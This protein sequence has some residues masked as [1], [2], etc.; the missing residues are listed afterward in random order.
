MSTLRDLFT[1]ETLVQVAF[2]WLILYWVL[3][4]LETTVAGAF[5][6]G[7][8]FIA[9]LVVI[10]LMRVFAYFELGL[11]KCLRASF[12][13]RGSSFHTAYENPNLTPNDAAL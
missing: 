7:V 9:I 12:T 11:A 6:R 13:E 2:L 3:R 5:I 10:A 8:G 4:Y 1:V